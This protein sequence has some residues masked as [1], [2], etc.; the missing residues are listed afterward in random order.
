M[1]TMCLIRT[2]DTC[3]SHLSSTGGDWSA[4]IPGLNWTVADCVAHIAEGLLWYATD[5]VAGHRELSTMDMKVRPASSPDD[6]IRTVS[7]FGTVLVRTVE[8]SPPAAVGWHPYGLGDASAFAAMGCAELLVHTHDA[9]LGLET[10]F[11]PD[12]ALA[13]ATLE[14]L[15][16][17]APGGHPAWETLLWA[18]NRVP[19]AD[20]PRPDGWRWTLGSMS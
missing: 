11:T 18:H 1:D 2:L 3:V 6:L 9:S 7:T 5:L 16:P 19:L 15:F 14:R 20:F 8:A 13:E 17:D 4:R 10:S 12:P